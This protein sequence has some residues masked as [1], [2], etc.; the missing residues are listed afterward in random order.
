[1]KIKVKAGEV[2]LEVNDGFENC[3]EDFMPT[4]C[5]RKEN[6]DALVQETER[7]LDKCDK[8]NKFLDVN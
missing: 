7:L 5:Q 3:G 8:L 2:E 1:M 4:M 6:F